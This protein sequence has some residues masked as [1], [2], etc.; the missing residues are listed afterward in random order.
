[1]PRADVVHAIWPKLREC[2][3]D[4]QVV[5]VHQSQG[6]GTCDLWV[7]AMERNRRDG[8]TCRLHRSLGMEGSRTIRYCPA[9]ARREADHDGVSAPHQKQLANHCEKRPRGEGREGNS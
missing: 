9:C 5:R 3:P 4:E 2:G 8:L 6:E 7:D 1:M